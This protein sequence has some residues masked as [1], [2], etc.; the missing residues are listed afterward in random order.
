M[1]GQSHIAEVGTSE[2]ENLLYKGIHTP[3]PLIRTISTDEKSNIGT[4]SANSGSVTH[5]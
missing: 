2:G 5:I 4:N 3:L 1:L